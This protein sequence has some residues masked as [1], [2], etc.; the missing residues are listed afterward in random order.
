M[1]DK[2]KKGS[3]NDGSTPEKSKIWDTYDAMKRGEP[4]VCSH[5]LW[6]EFMD[7]LSEA[8][9]KLI[10]KQIDYQIKEIASDMKKKDRG[11]IPGELKS[12][13]DELFKV[14]E[15]VIDW[16][17]YLR[18]FAGSSD[19]VYTKKT[20]RKLNKRFDENPALKIKCKKHILIGM[21]TSGS[22]SDSDLM[23]FFNEIFHIYKTGTKVTIVE[24]DAQIH[25][26]YEYK[27]KTPSLVSG[28]GGTYMSPIVEY[29]N[30]FH[31]KFNTLIILTD[32]YCES[33]PTKPRGGQMLWTICSNGINLESIQQFPGTKVKITRNDK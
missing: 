21:D 30:K 24:G 4:T 5:E 17:A 14:V 9:R 1:L 28:R 27:G 11:T 3:G 23:E 13:I 12:Y 33:N 20:R 6:K 29:Y 16:K 22:V 15:P 8:D 7:C 2:M 10:Q 25:N 31:R 19:K 26:V 32:G 18:R